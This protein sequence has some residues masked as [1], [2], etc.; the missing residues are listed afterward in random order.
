MLLIVFPA[1]L[2]GWLLHASGERFFGDYA[3]FWTASVLTQ[4]GRAAEAYRPE[5]HF[6][7]Q[8]ALFGARTADQWAAFLYPPVFLLVCFGLAWLPFQA[9]AVIWVMATFGLLAVALRALGGTA[10]GAWLSLAAFPAVWLNAGFGQNGFLS[11]ALFGLGAAALERHPV[12]AGMAFGGLAFKPQLALLVPVGLL[13]AHRWRALASTFLTA[14]TLCLASLAAF[15]PEPWLGFLSGSATARSAME[16]GN[17]GFW[18]M[19][20]PFAAIRLAGG[21]VAMAYAVQVV[22]SAIAATVLALV[23]RRRPGGRAEGATL[24]AAALLATP[25]LH[26]YD[27]VVLAVPMTWL[28]AE[29]RHGGF[30]AWEKTVLLL[31]FVAPLL[32]TLA[33]LQVALAVT[34]VVAAALF[35]V[36]ARRGFA[37][38]LAPVGSNGSTLP[39]RTIHQGR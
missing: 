32:G 28:L 26:I 21:G 24:V 6:A 16:T 3:S 11:A 4:G 1:L 37:P 13:A 20:S 35:A 15:G 34:P 10:R 25:F 38:T 22:A 29:G 36:V 31:A 14:A 27:L 2:L 39:S 17:A 7:L 12:L 18:K 8:F 19:A 33:A 23:C 30:A 5:A 9:S